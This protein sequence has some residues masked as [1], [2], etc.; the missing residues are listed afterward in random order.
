M[1][2]RVRARDELIAQVPSS[3]LLFFI[4]SF[5]FVFRSRKECLFAAVQRCWVVHLIFMCESFIFYHGAQAQRKKIRTKRNE[6]GT[7]TKK[8]TTK[9]EEETIR[10]CENDELNVGWVIYEFENDSFDA[11]VCNFSFSCVSSSFMPEFFLFYFWYFMFSVLLLSSIWMCVST[12][13][14]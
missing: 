2:A 13:T 11:R 8:Y 4:F 14:S 9:E 1:S 10:P 5:L 6:T 7:T 3:F 12:R